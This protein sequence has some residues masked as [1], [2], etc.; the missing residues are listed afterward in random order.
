MRLVAASHPPVCRSGQQYN[1]LR[2]VIV[3]PEA[4]AAAAGAGGSRD[5][6][7]GAGSG[8]GAAAGGYFQSSGVRKAVALARLVDALQCW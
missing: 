1:T 3:P 2:T 4:A 6:T 7:G 8:G 5:E